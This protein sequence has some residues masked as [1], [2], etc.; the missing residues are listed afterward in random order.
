MACNTMLGEGGIRNC[1][2]LVTYGSGVRDLA[3]FA[4]SNCTS[5]PNSHQ[6]IQFSLA[7]SPLNPWTHLTFCVVG[8]VELTPARLWSTSKT[9][10]AT[11]VL[12][13][14]LRIL[15]GRH[16]RGRWDESDQMVQSTTL[17]EYVWRCESAST[18]HDRYWSLESWW[19]HFMAKTNAVVV[20]EPL[21]H[22]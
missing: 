15:Y 2:Y 12:S 11:V 20:S 3:A 10:H 16:R 14:S 7:W 9:M 4:I 21:Q 19:I 6:Q 1:T 17:H 18:T 5:D 8:C 13:T 22:L